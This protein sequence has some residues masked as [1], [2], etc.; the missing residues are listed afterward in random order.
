MSGKGARYKS[1]VYNF[2]KKRHTIVEFE[3][4]LIN[5]QKIARNIKLTSNWQAHYPENPIIKK[6]NKG[7]SGFYENRVHITNGDIQQMILRI[8]RLLI[9]P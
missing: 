1:F 9:E 5:G 3:V 8:E 6:N 7:E 4:D 2:S